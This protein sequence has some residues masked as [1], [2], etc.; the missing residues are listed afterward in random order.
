MDINVLYK[1]LKYVIVWIFIYFSTKNI[2]KQLEVKD[3]LI[4]TCVL[5][6][7][8]YVIDTVFNTVRNCIVNTDYQNKF[9][10]QIEMYKNMSNKEDVVLQDVP[11]EQP[12][13]P[14]EQPIVPKE[15][16]IVPKEQPIVPK[17]QPIVPVV[18]QDDGTRVLNRKDFRGAENWEQIHTDN[19]TRNDLLNNNMRYSDFDRFPPN[20]VKNDYE[21][22]YSFMPPKD[23][24]PTP[25]Y[26]PVCVTNNPSTVQPVYLDTMTM[27]LKH[28]H[29]TTK[30]TP[31]DTFNT[32]YIINELN[33]R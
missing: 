14:K 10:E 1:F 27:D 31:P 4:I 3:V 32:D 9:D 12:I 18:P 19:G 30:I 17:E 25:L 13:V 16:P 28:W 7:L 20:I 33:S 29:E 23:W 8:V 15:Q 5:T 2:D 6:I 24:Y 22:G 26:P 11:K 21:M